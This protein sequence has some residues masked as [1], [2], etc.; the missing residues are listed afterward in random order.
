MQAGK[1]SHPLLNIRTLAEFVPFLV[2]HR[3]FA[4]PPVRPTRDGLFYI[5]LLLISFYRRAPWILTKL[6]GAVVPTLL[7]L[8]YFINIKSLH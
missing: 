2:G 7:V 6:C 3:G 4:S 8:N 1:K 5:F